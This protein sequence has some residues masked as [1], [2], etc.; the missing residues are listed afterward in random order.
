MYCENG[1]T[2]RAD[3]YGMFDLKVNDILCKAISHNSIY[4]VSVRDLAKAY[5]GGDLQQSGS[6]GG[7]TVSYS[8][9]INSDGNEYTYTFF[10]NQNGNHSPYLWVAGGGRSFAIDE[11]HIYFDGKG[12]NY[13]DVSYFQE[14]I[15]SINSKR[16]ANIDNMMKFYGVDSPNDIPVLP[17][18]AMAFM[19]N[20][21]SV[22]PLVEGRT[23]LMDNDK[24]CEY[25]FFGVGSS[26]T[27]F[28]GTNGA[29]LSVTAG[30]VYNVNK[31]EDFA[32]IFG[33]ASGTMT[34]GAGGG[35][36]AP[37]GVYSEIL[38]GNSQLAGS[39]GISV[40][41]YIQKQDDWV[42]GKAPITWYTVPSNSG[43]W[44]NYIGGEYA[45]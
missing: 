9:N 36:I 31:P 16:N 3:V 17:P 15:C 1:P 14:L 26:V 25:V 43:T 5:G 21:R 32:G 13:I 12:T 10:T 19:E 24:Y 8:T 41:Y 35:A 30:Y 29:D 44:S 40:T 33:A 6:G 23:I 39:V 2:I 4:Y 37:N 18:N 27:G 22:G 7:R 42:Y 11:K 34:I 38:G 45:I 20:I 28:V